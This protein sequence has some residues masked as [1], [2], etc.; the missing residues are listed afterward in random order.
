[1]KLTTNDLPD[2][3]LIQLKEKGVSLK[4]YCSFPKI[5]MPEIVKFLEMNLV[6]FL[7]CDYSDPLHFFNSYVTDFTNC[8]LQPL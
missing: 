3:L 5:P 2:L 6:Q 4:L 8:N 1:M 7:Q